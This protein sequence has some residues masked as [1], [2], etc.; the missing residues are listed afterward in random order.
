[1]ARDDSSL[2]T[3]SSLLARLREEP[4]N[5]AAWG[6]FVDCYGPKLYAWCR[7]WELQPAD[8]EDVTQAVLMKLSVQLRT[9]VYDPAR[10]F[11]AWL[12][13]VAQN[14]WNDYVTGKRR[15]IP[16]SGD[17]RVYAVLETV[18]ARDDLV[19]RLEESFDQELLSLATTRV[20]ER[21]EPHTWEAFQLT[22]L[23]GRSG[24]EAAAVLQIQVGTVF[25]AK[26]KIQKML[27]EEIER[28]ENEEAP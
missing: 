17:S 19:A 7:R 26:S 10:R 24:A 28:L 23:E 11:R 6:E 5:Q 21:V 13:T 2:R 22:A 4:E 3:R 16:G 15:A 25:K 1:M 8:A 9:F 14:A 20:R 12:K 18:E 27:R